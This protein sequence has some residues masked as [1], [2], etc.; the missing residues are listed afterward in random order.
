MQN[1]RFPQLS[2]D[3]ITAHRYAEVRSEKKRRQFLLAHDLLL[4]SKS[5]RPLSYSYFGRLA[6]EIRTATGVV[7][8]WHAVRH[9]FFNRA[10]SL[11]ISIED[12]V[13]R[14]IKLDDLVYWG[15]WS[16]PNSLNIYV[17]A[18]R[19]ERARKNL[20]LWQERGS[21]WTALD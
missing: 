2:A 9:A 19:T 14:Q 7:F 4:V 16:D 12:R 8:H 17:M 1:T 21:P 11:V 10:Y 5:G 3:Y 13:D 15:G 6:S 18:A 20:M